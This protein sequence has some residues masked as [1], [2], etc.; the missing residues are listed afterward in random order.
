[1]SLAEERGG[2]E[3]LLTYL[4]ANGDSSGVDW[5][6]TFLEEGPM[7][8]AARDAGLDVEV[9]V[10][11]RMR[12]ARRFTRTVRM[13]AKRLRAT[14]ADAVLSWM[15]KAHYYG[16]PAGALAR[17]PAVWYQHGRAVPGARADAALQRLPARGIVATSAS[18]A[19]AQEAMRPTRPIR[20]VH[21][22]VD[23]RLLDASA[24]PD[25][26]RAR[27]ELGLTDFAPVIG[28]VGR[29]QRWKGFHHMIEALP[30]LR[31]TWPGIV[32]VVVG[33]DHPSE[34]DYGAALERRAA[35]LGVSGSLVLAG[36][37]SD[38]TPWFAAM[39]VF[40]HLSDYEPFGM[41]ILESMATGTPVVASAAGGPSEIITDGVN[42]LLIDPSRPGDLAEA[43]ARYL[44]APALRRS[45]V[46]AARERAS[47]FSV[48]RFRSELERAVAELAS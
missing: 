35:E 25:A 3:R 19:E 43:V 1:M 12:D 26:A 8:A 5:S 9:T 47:E 6:L 33:G 4:L 36:W 13:L 18:V 27:R 29:L 40:V 10:A 34:P 48:A 46:S 23:P 17:V 14:Q 24:P 44:R 39:D 7:V 22:A 30:E 16:G 45:V 42:G 37:Q 11:G 2:A 32:Y 21:P 15:P 20:V 38:V 28:T 31:R 41:V